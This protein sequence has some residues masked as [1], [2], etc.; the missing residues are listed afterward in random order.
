MSKI[1][2]STDKIAVTAT[3]VNVPEID[4]I[5]SDDLRLPSIDLAHKN[6]NA[7]ILQTRRSSN[8]SFVTLPEISSDSEHVSRVLKLATELSTKSISELLSMHTS[9]GCTAAGAQVTWTMTCL[10]VGCTATRG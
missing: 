6:P 3:P 8:L 7:N 9:G 5:P 1:V 2:K 4:S 10:L